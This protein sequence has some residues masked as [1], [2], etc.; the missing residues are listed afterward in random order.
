MAGAVVIGVASAF[1]IS[2]WLWAFVAFGAFIAVSYNLELFGRRFHN[3]FWFAASWGAFPFL[4]A[5]WVTAERLDF[6]A[7]LLAGGCFALSL[8][9]RHLSNRVRNLRRNVASISGTVHYRDGTS[10]PVRVEDF[11]QAPEAALQILS[12]FSVMLAG[13]WLAVRM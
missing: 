10:F 2:Q 4:T 13:G 3:D 8:G 11:I 9:Q 6:G 5:Y 7:G 12:V 1:M